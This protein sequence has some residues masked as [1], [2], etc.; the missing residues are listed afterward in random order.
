[1]KN[2][3]LLFLTA[4]LAS[5]YLHA[6]SQLE[7]NRVFKGDIVPRRQMVE[8][9]VKGQPLEK[10][11]LTYYHSVQFR[12]TKEQRR[13]VQELADAEKPCGVET[14]RQGG[15][16]TSIMIFPRRGE[17]Y[18]YLCITEQGD[19]MTLVYMEGHVSST[20]ELRKIIKRNN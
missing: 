2:R 19:E 3:I 6:Q 10:Y 5:T 20:K 18:V 12:A 9:R 17:L 16:K 14:S 8:V 7:L 13:R 4:L 11:N 1:M 15:R